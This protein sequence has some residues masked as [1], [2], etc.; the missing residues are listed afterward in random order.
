M[1]G[2]TIA[3]AEVDVDLDGKRIPAQARRIGQQAARSMNK[4][5]EKGGQQSGRSWSK[6]YRRG[7]LRNMDGT[8]KLV[9]GLI[10]TMGPQIAA[11]GS[12]A[13]AATTALLG[14]ALLGVAGGLTAA[15][16]PLLAF[17]A[18]IGLLVSGWKDA[19]KEGT[20]LRGAMD[21]LSEAWSDQADTLFTRLSPALTELI[22]SLGRLVADSSIGD[23]FGR[24]MAKV[25][26]AFT[27]VV[28]SPQV[29][30]FMAVLEKEIPNALTAAG[31]GL[32][33]FTQGFARLFAVAAPYSQQLGEMFRGMG[34]AFA[35]S[36][37]EMAAS[38][39]LDQIFS[40]AID[41][42]RALGGLLG[43]LTAALGNVFLIG[44]QYG[45]SMLNTLGALADRFL[46]FT[47]SAEGASQIAQW[48]AQGE[49]VF[50]ALLGV[51]GALGTTLADMVTPAVVN[52]LIMFLHTVELILPTLGQL[53][54]VIGEDL[55][56]LD[57]FS[58]ALLIVN[59]ALAPIL[60]V[61]ST[62][63][64]ILGG[65]L[66]GALISLG[67]VLNFVG[68]A[69]GLI[70]QPLGLLTQGLSDF[71]SASNF[72]TTAM[73]KIPQALGGIGA[74]LQGV[75][76]Q[77]AAAVPSIVTAAGGILTGL[78][79]GIVQALP[80]L[81]ATVSSALASIAVE[82]AG[83][84]PTLL[85]AALSAVDGIVAGLAQSAPILIAGAQQMISVLL[86]AIVGALPQLQTSLVGLVTVGGDIILQLIQGI[87]AAL[88][89]LITT[90]ASLATTLVSAFA[91]YMPQVVNTFADALP[92]LVTAILDMIPTIIAAGQQLFM[93]F[94]TALQTI[95]PQ[96]VTTLTTLLP[97]IASA[98]VA[99]IPQILAAALQLFDTMI[100]A[101]VTVMPQ[102]LTQLIGLLPLIV[103][104]IMS[105]LPTLINAAITMFLTLVQGLLAAV[106]QLITALT[107]QVLP[108][109]L[110]ALTTMIPAILNGALEMFLGIVTA[111]A[112]ALPQILQAIFD[113]LPALVQAIV[114]MIPQIIDAATTLFES[115]ID[116]LTQALPP[117]LEALLGILPDLVKQLITMLPTIINAAIDL[118]LGLVTGLGQ[119][120]PQILSALFGILPDLISMIVKMIPTLVSAA[121]DLF[122]AIVTGLAQAV[123]QII[124]AVIGL[125]PQLISALGKID[126]AGAGRAIM[127]SLLDGLKAAWGGVTDFVGGIGSWIEEHKGP[128][129][130]DRKLLVGAG[131]AIMAGLH[132][133][134]TGGWRR[135]AGFVGVVAGEIP[136]TFRK[137]LQIHS[138]SKVMFKLGEQTVEGFIRGFRAAANRGRSAF[139]ELTQT[140]IK[141]ITDGLQKGSAEAGKESQRILAKVRDIQ[142]AAIKENDKALKN[143]IK[144][145]Q[146]ADL[147]KAKTA[148]TIADLRK[149]YAA[150]NQTVKDA[151]EQLR[152]T[153]KNNARQL[154][155]TLKDYESVQRQ[156]ESARKKLDEMRKLRASVAESIRGQLDLGSLVSTEEGGAKPTF[157]SV[158]AYV[159]GMKSKAQTFA[160]RMKKLVSA[161]LPPAFIQ[162][163]AGLGL[164]GAIQVSDALLQ[165]S[166]KQLAKLKADF[167]AF[168]TATTSVGDSVVKS[169]YGIGVSAQ[170]GLIRGLVEDSGDLKKAAKVFTDRLTR[171]VRQNLGIKS[172][173]RVFASIGEQVMNGMTVGIQRGAS[174]V[175]NAVG[176]VASSISAVSP[177]VSTSFGTSRFGGA[178]VAGVAAGNGRTV[179]VQ[180]GAIQVV[181]P[182]ADP[183]LVASQVL[184]RMMVRAG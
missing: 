88:P 127:N 52:S 146:K 62:F 110:Q 74:V 79:D 106:P 144:S 36:V 164:D 1:A 161:G 81:L 99:A 93:S 55:G 34:E 108:A 20:A 8:V 112:Q 145:V 51:V 157:A 98:V 58:A 18:G 66:Y 84:A 172:P 30:A 97:Q 91:E 101:F 170:E 142:I 72:A 175:L 100:Q 48:F 40:G 156:L 131:H 70:A 119:A 173:S 122:L 63:A 78:A 116:G 121:I 123:P 184:D 134:L 17:V 147:G 167:S 133:G 29:A 177:S 148:S 155:T 89:Q 163:I 113:I 28:N 39:K 102:L 45:V 96:L 3:S 178:T 64:Q 152:T 151:G 16:G 120:L 118:F 174:G 87:V 6:G 180:E 77:I 2:P 137:T 135:V 166:P 159:S 107:T 76:T 126:L 90:I 67:P 13:A 138:P 160:N 38:G 71:S 86:K 10:A 136:A 182:L 80:S 165:G 149:T 31:Q 57:L 5:M 69:I 46:E 32:A 181:T 83:L 4:D 162:Q 7:V 109:I 125:G 143:A 50:N 37:D 42:L 65:A 95:L 139:G 82:V 183:Y 23:A 111:L 104:T 105:M 85:S 47:R 179:V 59:N 153:I 43:P 132:E 73:E 21:G 150:M 68:E 130:Y 19:T 154:T 24:S 54:S 14:S 114:S 103:T 141:S 22:G 27:G 129:S 11:L 56:V 140:A 33:S 176:S 35:A 168:N 53:L 117:I 115:I 41:S 49:R 171:Y 15:I 92:G 26:E 128:L 9:L 158:A 169:M 94:I 12:G 124:S 75:V 44:N 61:L 60:P 25:A